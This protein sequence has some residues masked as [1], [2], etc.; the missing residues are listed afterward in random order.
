M[1]KNSTLVAATTPARNASQTITRM[2][3]RT[4]S[5]YTFAVG[6]VSVI[7]AAKLLLE[8]AFGSN[9]PFD[10]F[11]AAVMGTAWYAGLGP[12]LAATFLGAA[13]GH[14]LF[15]EPIFTILKPV[16]GQNFLPVLFVVE[17][18][19][20]C[21]L[22]EKLRLARSEC[23]AIG[24]EFRLLV[25]GTMHQSLVLLDRTGR[26][27]SW[28]HG[29]RR[30]LGY[31]TI[32]IVDQNY[33]IF[34]PLEEDRNTPEGLLATASGCGRVEVEGWCTRKDG[35][36]FWAALALT[37]L[38][39]VRG[40]TT[41]FVLATWDITD[42]WHAERSLR[43]SERQLRL[44]ADSLPVLIAYVDASSRYQ[45]NNATYQKWFG[46][47]PESCRGVHVREL[48]GEAAYELI[49]DR[50]RS[51]LFL[52][53]PQSFEAVMPYQRGG[54]RHVH[55]DCIP[56]RT[57]DGLIAG[58]FILKA[59]I[60]EQK[61]IETDLRTGEERLRAIVD[62]AADAIITLDRQGTLASVNVAAEKMFGYSASDMVGQDIGL[63]LAIP[64]MVARGRN[65][66]ES[67]RSTMRR[68]IRSGREVHAL[69]SDGSTFPVEISISET[70]SLGLFVGI[71]RDVTERMELEREVLE[72]TARE[73]RR[74][75]Q[76]LHDHV[77]QELTGLELLV[78]TVVVQ[79]QSSQAIDEN[80][81]RKIADALRQVHKDVRSLACGLL[82]VEIH[83]NGLREALEALAKNVEQS[84]MRCSFKA[85]KSVAVADAATATHLFR[86]VQEAVSN[87]IR[88][89]HPERI[90]IS[91]R[92]EAGLLI[93]EV[94]DDGSGIAAPHGLPGLGLRL[95]EYRA[96][97]IGGKLTVEPAEDRGTVVLC[98]VLQSPTRGSRAKKFS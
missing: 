91:L 21:Y 2:S 81:V 26:V 6:S 27:K 34:F 12:G 5:G 79:T 41:G 64:E 65:A 50:I 46:I 78:D 3:R 7:A 31:S 25:D 61:R 63:F 55:V 22:T 10:L 36:Q 9:T 70:G 23:E 84:G 54:T 76:D 35:S 20:I 80:L 56:H 44:M 52:G 8:P 15:V 51:V 97:L 71:L 16:S 47:A 42:R 24:N 33:S 96:S 69:R 57:A 60:S 11:F 73:Q 1:G 29:A 17:G 4:L 40:Q 58:C 53:E 92:L 62:T 83:P 32:D 38:R 28:N 14:Y 72:A 39:N 95:M 68:L 37:A 93:L 18:S 90:E 13:L 89:G 48:Q 85:G 59:D 67:A 77:G 74:I 82:P 87:A 49:K 94:K 98:R 66:D 30:V 45:F 43:E 75:G 88:H 19:L 86:I